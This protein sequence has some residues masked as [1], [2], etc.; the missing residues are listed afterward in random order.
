LVDRLVTMERQAED[1]PHRR[2]NL[3]LNSVF[4]LRWCELQLAWLDE[5]ERVLGSAPDIADGDGSAPHNG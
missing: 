2:A 3:Q 1:L 4:G 5:A